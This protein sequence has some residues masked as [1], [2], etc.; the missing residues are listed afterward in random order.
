MARKRKSKRIKA[1]SVRVGDFIRVPTEFS[2]SGKTTNDVY[3]LAKK[4][5]KR[6]FSRG[7]AYRVTVSDRNEPIFMLSEDSVERFPKSGDL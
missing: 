7:K 1:A 6:F 4:E 2:Q 3:V 5:V